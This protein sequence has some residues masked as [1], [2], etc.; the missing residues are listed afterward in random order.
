V[1]TRE[2]LSAPGTDQQTPRLARLGDLLGELRADA[3]AAHQA[4]VEQRPRGPVTGLGPLDQA[5]GG[6]LAVGCHVIT[7]GPGLGKTALALQ[8]AATCGCPALYVTCEMGPI[9]LLRR[10][11]ARTTGTFLGRLKDGELPPDQIMALATQ[12]I[13]AAPDLSIADATCAPASPAWLREAATASRGPA[14][15]L[16]VVIDSLH[17]WSDAAAEDTDE[18]LRLGAGMSALRQLA[19]QLG[20][21]VVVVSER[22]RASMKA[23]GLSAAAG[24]RKV[25]YIAETVLGLD[26]DPDGAGRGAA[27]SMVNLVCSIEKNRSGSPGAQLRLRFQGALQRFEAA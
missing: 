18:Y 2:P 9:E 25:E 26:P 19:G 20:A 27:M 8:I 24:S 10:V 3:D 7:A 22:N 12:A 5:L 21:A 15:H 11:I 16:L 6:L 1:L 4:R 17:S 23:G 13:Q 14:E